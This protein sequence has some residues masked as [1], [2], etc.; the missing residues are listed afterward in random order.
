MEKTEIKID[1]LLHQFGILHKNKWRHEAPAGLQNLAVE[2][3]LSARASHEFL[4][5]L[6]AIPEVVAIER[7]IPDSVTK[8]AE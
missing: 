5:A 8:I 4:N 6:V 7:D 3:Q 1:Y 2:F